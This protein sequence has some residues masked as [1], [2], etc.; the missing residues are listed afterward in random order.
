MLRQPYN[1]LMTSYKRI[2][3]VTGSNTGIGFDIVRTLAEQGHIV[4]L[5]AR[6][7]DAGLAAQEQLASAGLG[8]K[9]VQLDVTDPSSIAAA[10][11][12][13]EQAEGRL[14]SLVHNAAISKMAE[15]KGALASPSPTSR[16]HSQRISSVSSPSHRHSS[17]A[18]AARPLGMHAS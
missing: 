14:D 13:L 11:D 9:F 17:H 12:I 8:V 10:K 6:N 2:I 4:Y 7:K 18:C 5:S 16:R 15:S 3:L 1:A